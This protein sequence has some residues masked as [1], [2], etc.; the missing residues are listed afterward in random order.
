MVKS[1][2]PKVFKVQKK[3]INDNPNNLV[4][5]FKNLSKKQIKE[6]RSDLDQF[7]KAYFG[8]EEPEE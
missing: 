3:I 2:L 4:I 6:F 7:A 1:T 8:P 5:R